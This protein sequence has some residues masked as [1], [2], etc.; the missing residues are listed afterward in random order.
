MTLKNTFGVLLDHN[1][2][3]LMTKNSKNKS[4]N[5]DKDF[6]DKKPSRKS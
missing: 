5:K 1:Q 2:S 6:K 3:L 4:K